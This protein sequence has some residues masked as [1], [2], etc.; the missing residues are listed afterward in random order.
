MIESGEKENA[1]PLATPTKKYAK[2]KNIC[3]L[4][5][6]TL[7]RDTSY[8]VFSAKGLQK[9]LAQIILRTCG[10]DIKNNDPISVRI[11]KSCHI[12]VMKMDKF[13]DECQEAQVKLWG[14]GVKVKRM[15]KSP[16]TSKN[17]S[18]IPI[19]S[20]KKKLEYQHAV[21]SSSNPPPETDVRMKTPSAAVRSPLQTINESSTVLNTA[22][23]SSSEPTGVTTPIATSSE[24]IVHTLDISTSIAHHTTKIPPQRTPV[25]EAHYLGA[26]RPLSAPIPVVRHHSKIPTLRTPVSIS[27]QPPLIISPRTPVGVSTRR[28][29]RTPTKIPMA[30]ATPHKVLPRSRSSVA[31]STQRFVNPSAIEYTTMIPLASPPVMIRQQQNIIVTS[32]TSPINQ[33]LVMRTPQAVTINTPNMT[34][35][36]QSPRI[37]A[38]VL[39]H[40]TREQIQQIHNSAKKLCSKGKN[41]SVL[42]N[43]K[44]EDLLDFDIAKVWD[45]LVKNQPILA[46]AMLAMCEKERPSENFYTSLADVD[47]EKRLKFSFVYSILMHQRWNYN[48]LFQRANTIMLIDGGST[49]QC[50]LRMN[51]LGIHLHPSAKPRLLKE[52]GDH[53]LDTLILSLRKGK[54]FR[55]TCDNLDMRIVS[56]QL[57]HDH[58]SQD[59]HLISTNFIQNRLNFSHL[60]NNKP[61]EDIRNLSIQTYMLSVSEWKK[62]R[63]TTMILVG[64]LMIEFFPHFSFLKGVTPEHITHKYSEEMKQKSVIISMPIINGSE[65][66]YADCIKA[67]R[68][69]EGWIKEIYV[70]AGLIRE[71]DIPTPQNPPIPDGGAH[72]GQIYGHRNFTE[73]DPMKEMKVPV[74]GDQLTRVRFCGAKDLVADSLTPIDRLEHCSPFKCAMWHA[75]ASLLQYG[76]H[77]LYDDHSATQIGTLNYARQKY[78]RKNVTPKKVLDSLQGSE[79]LFINLGR[80]YIVHALMQYF[81]LDDFDGTPTKHIFTCDPKTATLEEKQQF[82]GDALGKFVDEFI[83]HNRQYYKRDAEEDDYK[84]NYGLCI[85]FLTILIMQL[86]DTAKEGDGERNLI[87]QKLMLC[88]FRSQSQYSKYAKEMFVAISQVECL[89]TPQ[90]SEQFKWSYFVNWCG[91]AGKNMEEDLSHEI[92]NAIA[93]NLIRQMGA[94]KT[95]TS[96]SRVMRA[97]SGMKLLVDHYDRVTEAKGRSSKHTK[98]SFLEEEKKMVK[99]LEKFKPFE[100]KARYHKSFKKIKRSPLMYLNPKEFGIWLDSCMKEFPG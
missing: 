45:E 92:T 29:F 14:T 10:V 88:V 94:N 90:L 39:N 62:Y 23:R 69:I 82:L 18:S 74:S 17:S 95:M 33:H 42:N 37:P 26:T 66:E 44:Y 83:I 34:I 57:T 84:K 47:H 43:C 80:A 7:L 59:L 12:F 49:K 3:R 25:P 4:C 60:D 6:K 9:K 73:G 61:K 36:N 48:S 86:K 76:Y 5:L 35:M 31:S 16:V 100:H 96:I 8:N 81:G 51:N 30:V 46:Q 68:E 99:D 98:L 85:I 52:I 93:K 13:R 55:A 32:R 20:S 70:K 2:D 54:T 27:P 79:D 24:R 40:L 97:A 41:K 67:L 21:T 22:N 89:L 91:G 38:A 65:M 11:C 77:L 64:R 71:E 15:H 1:T 19:H 56:G 75:K 63:S 78:T 87:N 58:Q 28:T 72:Q 53:Y 50:M